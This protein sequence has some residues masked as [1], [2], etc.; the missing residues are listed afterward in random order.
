MMY[1][2]SLDDFLTYYKSL[3]IYS[4]WKILKGNLNIRG[5]SIYNKDYVISLRK[6]FDSKHLFRRKVSIAE[7]VSWLDSFNII[8]RLAYVLNSKLDEEEY[9][10][11][12]LFVEYRINHSK[13]RRVDYILKYNKKLLLV[14]FRL[15]EK[16]PNLSGMWQK[17]ELELIIYKELMSNYLDDYDMKIYAFIAMPE[18]DGMEIIN[19]Q[20]KYN[21]NNIV[22]FAE[23]IKEYLIK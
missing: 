7:I 20:V 14:E 4:E 10:N 15:S 1:F 12:E 22:Y 2:S 8:K 11:L 6:L 16:F 3:N 5:N 21:D 19:K 13:N 9:N 23:Y 17:K 18:Y